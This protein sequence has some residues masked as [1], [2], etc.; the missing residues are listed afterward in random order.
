M[1]KKHLALMLGTVL[2][3]SSVLAACGENKP[4]E[5]SPEA[6]KVEDTKPFP[7]KLVINQVGE[8]P[9]KD[10]EIEKQIKAYTNTDL[11]IQWLPTSTYDEKVN[12]MV[13]A[14]ELPTVIKLGYNATSIGQMKSGLFWEIGPYIKDYKNLAAQNQV[15]YDNLSVEGKLYGVPLFRDLGRAIIHYRKDW[16]D[17]MGLT[18][19]KTLDDWY[20][21]AKVLTLNDPDKN[22]KNDTYGL[23]LEKKYNQDVSSTLTRIAVSQGAPNKWK[24]E[25]NGNFTPEFTTEPFFQTMKLFKR[26]YEEKL[27]NQ[28]FAAVD[29]TETAKIYESGRGGI[30]LSGGNAQSLQDK[31]VKVVP[32]A[33]MDAAPVEGPTGRRLPGEPGNAGFWAIPKATVKTEAEMK[34]V[35]AFIDKLMD[36]KM[37]T[38]LVK[39]VEG[40]HWADKGEFTEVLNRDADAKEVKP[41]RDTFPNRNENYNIA[42]KAKQPDLFRKN[43][44]IGAENEKYIVPNPA[45]NLL[46]GTYSERGKELEQMITDAETKFIMGKIDE[47]GWQAEVERWKKAGGDKLMQE[48]K[49]AYEKSKKK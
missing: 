49:E 4:V 22:G 7:I 43:S 23:I 41:Y 6:A 10:N 38:L 39:G 1:S 9:P 12:V 37:A 32:T 13:A 17:T 8:I 30:Q 35:L 34:K 27:I 47:A 18:P 48:Y 42:K 20:N 33:V 26:L 45:H 46:S 16:F 40:T 44:Q 31:V 25:S 36:P 29:G 21:I 28:D 11:E 15:F 19:P 5:G 24:I 3:T 2:L 14:S